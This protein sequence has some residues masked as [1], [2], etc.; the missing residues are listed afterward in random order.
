LELKISHQFCI[1]V[2]GTGS[3]NLG[4]LYYAWDRG[5]RIAFFFSAKRGL[6]PKREWESFCFVPTPSRCLSLL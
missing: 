4:I 1:P 5:T 6:D 2:S 3:N